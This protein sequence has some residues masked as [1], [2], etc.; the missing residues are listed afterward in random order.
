MRFIP[1]L[2]TF[3][4]IFVTSCAPVPDA[5]QVI[6]DAVS[7]HGG[8]DFDNLEVTFD[9]RGTPYRLTKD[10]GK[11]RYERVRN[12]TSGSKILE[13]MDNNGAYKLINGIEQSITSR[14]DSLL[15]YSINAV[16]YFAV[17]PLQLINKAVIPRYIGSSEILG[18]DY[19]K[20]EITLKSDGGGSDYQ[21]RY[22]FWFEQNTYMMDYFAYYYHVNGGGSRFRKVVNTRNFNGILLS[23]QINFTSEKIST[24]I[25][26]YDKELLA[27]NLKEVS[28][29]KLENLK[30]EK[31]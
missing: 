10:G 9:F 4:V 27:G 7:A 17:L 29:I 16:R 11:F 25:E 30:V 22:I 15:K 12:D 2:L 14:E 28:Q 31:F 3:F 18:K 8:K 23:D 20:I 24:N 6:K 5:N 19:H 1:L 26:D 21:D 13:G